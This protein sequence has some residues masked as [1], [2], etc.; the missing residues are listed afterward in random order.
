MMIINSELLKECNSDNLSSQPKIYSR[1]K[2]MKKSRKIGI[3]FQTDHFGDWWPVVKIEV[4]KII[5]QN[6]FDLAENSTAVYI[7]YLC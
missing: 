3:K 4:K 1:P 5:V 6:K 7:W 2:W